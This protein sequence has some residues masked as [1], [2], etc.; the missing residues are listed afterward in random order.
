MGLPHSP[1]TA[2]RLFDAAYLES[3]VAAGASS[4]GGAAMTPPVAAVVDDAA[5]ARWLAWKARGAERDRRSGLI[6]GRLFAIPVIL[7]VGWLI[8]EFR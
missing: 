3:A 7:V 8:A 5:E 6:M 1:R 2:A 4:P